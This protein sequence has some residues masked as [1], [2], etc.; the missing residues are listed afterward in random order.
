MYQKLIGGLFLNLDKYNLFN[1]KKLR[2]NKTKYKNYIDNFL[3][4]PKSKDHQ[5]IPS[6]IN[7]I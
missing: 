7:K 3:K 6:L 5:N 2:V 1:L 4:H